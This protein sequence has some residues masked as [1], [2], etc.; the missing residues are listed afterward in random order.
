MPH[1][2]EQLMAVKRKLEPRNKPVQE[3]AQKQIQKIL[4]TTAQ[5]L[6]QVGQDDL[7]TILVAKHAGISVGTLYHY[8]P[9]KYAIMYTL[10]E[11]WVDEMQ[12]AIEELEAEAIEKQS[13]KIFVEFSIQRIMK[14]YLNQK[15]LL[16]LVQAMYGV[17][18]LQSLDNKHDEIVIKGMARMFARLGI[19]SDEDEL[20]RLGLAYLEISHALL[21][22]IV[23]KSEIA[24]NKTLADLKFLIFSLLERAKGQF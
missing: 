10:A 9:N 3:R 1:T 16:P 17:P 2:G 15:G 7:T 22:V 23:D 6:D 19:S 13:I 11:Q 8:F 18:E 20:L 5:L 12:K 14:V 24:D 4:S 21:L